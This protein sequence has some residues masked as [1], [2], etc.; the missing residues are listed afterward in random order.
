MKVGN[1]PLQKGLASTLSP[2]GDQSA[3]EV[4]VRTL[5]LDGIPL[6]AGPVSHRQFADTM[7]HLASSVCIVTSGEAGQWEG[8]TVTAM[9]SLSATPPS[10]VVSITKGSALAEQIV[11]TGG[12]S[13]AMLASDQNDIA[14]IF[15]GKSISGGRFDTGQWES[16]ASG[17]P[18]LSGAMAVIDCQLAGV[19]ELDTHCLFAG[20]F[21]A[22]E[23]GDHK[24]LLWHNRGYAY[25]AG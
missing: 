19:I 24:P 23:F 4:S 1:M 14:D 15:A 2:D 20:I 10:L 6:E 13:V 22:S 5:T 7:A 25:L 21:M 18:K 3:P 17:R 11:R 8:R 12:F 9:A 16:W